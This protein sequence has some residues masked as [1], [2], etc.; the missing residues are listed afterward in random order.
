MRLV[1]ERRGSLGESFFVPRMFWQ[2][3]CIILTQWG[4]G[5]EV[6]F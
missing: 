6:G 5:E 4:F 3:P 1:R 2:V